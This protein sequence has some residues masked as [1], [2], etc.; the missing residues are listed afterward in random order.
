MRA[1]EPKSSNGVVVSVA[2][3]P[4]SPMPGMNDQEKSRR[5]KVI[6]VFVDA[7]SKALSFSPTTPE[8]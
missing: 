6:P 4:F 3:S 7:D 8:E 1:T 2:V 5:T